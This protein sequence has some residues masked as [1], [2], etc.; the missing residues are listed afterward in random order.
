MEVIDFLDCG[1]EHPQRWKEYRD[2]IYVLPIP[3][4]LWNI[5]V[6]PSYGGSKMGL[7][8]STPRELEG[9]SAVC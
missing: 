5:L 4:C 7:S 6:Y 8:L 2:P 1:I 3:L 9:N